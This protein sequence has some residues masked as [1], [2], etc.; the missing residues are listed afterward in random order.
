MDN[1][2]GV[3]DL[4]ICNGQLWE[5]GVVVKHMQSNPVQLRDKIRY[6]KI[7]YIYSRLSNTHNYLRG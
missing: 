5:T 2:I 1:T 7:T 3:V 4:F 6:G